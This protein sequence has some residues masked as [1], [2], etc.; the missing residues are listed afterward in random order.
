MLS[1]KHSQD[2]GTY[3]TCSLQIDAMAIRQHVSYD[4]HS[5]K[6][7][8]FVDLGFDDVSSDEAKEVL[9]LLVVGTTGHWKTPV[10][11]YCTRSLSA[12]AQKQ[13]VLQ[14]ID[15]LELTGLHV[16]ALVMDGLS[17]N[18]TMCN[19][20]GCQLDVRWPLKT[21]FCPTE[22]NRKIYVILDACHMLK[23]VRNTLASCRIL[24]SESGHVYWSYIQELHEV[25][26]KA[27][28]RAANRLTSRHVDFHNQKMKVRLAAQT[29]SNSVAMAL[30]MMH[31]SG[32]PKFID[33]M[34]TVEFLQT[35]D[36]LF[37]IMNSR[38][39]RGFG[40]KAPIRQSNLTTVL[41]TLNQHRNYLLTLKMADGKYLVNSKKYEIYFLFL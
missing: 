41:E 1:Q 16:V 34:P 39:P 11:Y 5:G 10:A 14:A 22:S 35:M 23:L 27:G 13:L 17:A 3:T 9:V 40:F 26:Q 6:M 8:G 33:V 32:D 24:E 30:V 31:N 12:D 18:I 25:Q 36:T 19:L 29:L 28:L 37:D 15:E 7:T 4:A 2:P 38:N 20:L 21:W